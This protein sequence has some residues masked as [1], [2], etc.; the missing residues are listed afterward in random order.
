MSLQIGFAS[1]LLIHLQDRTPEGKISLCLYACC[2]VSGGDLTY[3]S[4]FMHFS[5]MVFPVCAVPFVSFGHW[6]CLSGYESPCC[7]MSGTCDGMSGI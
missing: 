5:G 4:V 6:M 7:G 2:L 1:V 3:L